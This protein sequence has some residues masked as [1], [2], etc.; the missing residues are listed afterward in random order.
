MRI[1]RPLS[2]KHPHAAGAVMA[3]AGALGRAVTV[4]AVIGNLVTDSHALA[5]ANDLETGHVIA[6]VTVQRVGAVRSTLIIGQAS[7]KPG[8]AVTILLN[9]HLGLTVVNLMKAAMT[10]ISRRGEI[11]DVAGAKRLRMSTLWLGLAIMCPAFCNAD[12][13]P[14]LAGKLALILHQG[15]ILLSVS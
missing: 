3:G 8:R 14:A 1:F 7:P 6:H 10:G 15:G 13:L 4:L 5:E 12:Q 2:R 9:R 11:R